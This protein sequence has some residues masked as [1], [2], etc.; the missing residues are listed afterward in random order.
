MLLSSGELIHFGQDNGETFAK[1]SSNDPSLVVCPIRIKSIS[2]GSNHT[3]AVKKNLIL[4]L[5]LFYFILFILK[6]K[7]S[8]DGIFSI[9][10]SKKCIKNLLEIGQLFAISGGYSLFTEK[11]QNL[12]VPSFFGVKK[13]F[14]VNN[15]KKKKKN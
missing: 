11:N 6:K 5:F 2:T 3:I 1:K 12:F 14:N 9:L 8:V 7:V 4:F 13:W 10:I 15:Y